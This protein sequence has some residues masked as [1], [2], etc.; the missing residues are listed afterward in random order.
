ML[1][2]KNFHSLPAPWSI[3]DLQREIL[4]SQDRCEYDR[5]RLAEL[6]RFQAGKGRGSSPQHTGGS[7]LQND[8]F[9]SSG[10]YWK[11]S[12]SLSRAGK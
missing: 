7:G 1:E 5:N 3:L 4:E 12:C 11:D 2:W 6:D 9:L 10:G 8:E